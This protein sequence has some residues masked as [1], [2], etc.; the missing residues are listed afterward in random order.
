MFSQLISSQ[1]HDLQATLDQQKKTNSLPHISQKAAVDVKQHRRSTSNLSDTGSK[2]FCQLSSKYSSQLIDKFIRS[3]LL[4]SSYDS[5][6]CQ[7]GNSSQLYS[8]LQESARGGFDCLHGSYRT[9]GDGEIYEVVQGKQPGR[10]TS[11]EG[12]TLSKAIRHQNLKKLSPLDS[13]STHTSDDYPARKQSMN[14]GTDNKSQSL[15]CMQSSESGSEN[16]VQHSSSGSSSSCTVSGGGV[17][18]KTMPT[19]E[20]FQRR[21]LLQMISAYDLQNKRLQRELAKEK[22]RRTEE[23]ACVV[24]SL[25]LFEAKL[26]NDLKSVNQ[27]MLDRDAEICRLTRLTR[28]LRKRLKDQQ[29]VEGVIDEQWVDHGKCL[30]L[31]EL[32][33]NNCRKQFYDID[34]STKREEFSVCTKAELD[35]SSDDTHS[36]SFCGVRRSV[37]YTSK[38]TAGTFRDYMRSRS[39]HIKNPAL[40]QHSEENTSSVSH[41]D[42]QT[43]YEQLQNYVRDLERINDVKLPLEIDEHSKQGNKELDQGKPPCSSLVTFHL[44]EEDDLLSPTQGGD[45]T[46][47]D[48]KKN[49]I[50]QGSIKIFQRRFADFSEASPKQIYETTTDDWYASASDQEESSTLAAKPY[51]R[52]AV[53]PVL[54]CVNQILLQQSME[55]TMV[56]LVPKSALASRYISNANLPRRSSLGRRP[57]SNGRKRVH[58]STKNSMV[59]VP[60]LNDQEAQVRRQIHISSYRSMTTDGKNDALNYGSIYSNEYEPIGSERASNFYVDMAATFTTNS[61]EKTA[62]S[63]ISKTCLKLPPALPPKPAN[64][65]KFQKS[66][67]LFGKGQQKNESDSGASITASEPDYCSISE[68]GITRNCVQ[69]VVDVHKAQESNSPPAVEQETYV[70]GQATQTKIKTNGNHSDDNPSDKIDEIEEILADIPKLPNVAAIIAPKQSD[71][72]TQIKPKAALQI[73]R[74]LQMTQH[75]QSLSRSTMQYKRKHVPYILAEIKKRISLPNSPSTS[76]SLSNTPA[77]KSVPRAMPGP[78]SE[79]SIQAEFDWYNLDAEYDRSHPEVKDP[80]MPV[81]ADEYNLDE[82][83]QQEEYSQLDQRME[84][85]ASALGKSHLEPARSKQMVLNL[86]D[87]EK[88]ID[89]SG[90]STKPLSY[91]RKTYLNAPIV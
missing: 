7:K 1:M 59:H 61:R 4:N 2:F 84:D 81:K 77:S 87:F 23:L 19:S 5:L 21:R 74:P 57:V 90:L 26:K 76:K 24:K 52:G 43:S 42:S 51:G 38:R 8:N 62:G 37:R 11:C 28:T 44:E 88:F 22:R 17:T 71:S 10:K 29:R 56:D 9:H 50:S 15:M 70:K 45:D 41:E 68:V 3:E 25:I 27:R 91:K 73:Q 69:I 31:K 89:G 54:E 49:T 16:K 12:Q 34:M 13:L 33:C 20:T 79:M 18:L 39:M 64:L 48:Q 86:A 66:P 40:E 6:I 30:V 80:E 36:S 55:E 67:Q 47:D 85:I 32:Q 63:G 78:S 46:D 53:N 60:L 72:D 83:F 82:A 35:S 65:L 75:S 58:F 14:P